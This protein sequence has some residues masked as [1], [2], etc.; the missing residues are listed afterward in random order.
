MIRAAIPLAI[1]AAAACAGPS[2]TVP[3]GFGNDC[4][5]GPRIAGKAEMGVTDE[6]PYTDTDA[7]I[8]MTGRTGGGC[9]GAAFDADR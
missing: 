4:G 1:V 9:A 6:G 7:K 3:T 5:D 8:V 2:S